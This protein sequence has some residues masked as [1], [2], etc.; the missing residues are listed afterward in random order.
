MRG[1]YGTEDQPGWHL[2]TGS[3]AP[4]GKASLKLDGIV[5]NA[6]Y[7]VNGAQRGKAY[8]YRVRAQFEGTSGTGQ[9][10]GKRKCDFLF[11]RR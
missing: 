10:V 7:A 8:S 5:S 6:D 4:Q 3:I 1:T 9:R 2:L 11:K